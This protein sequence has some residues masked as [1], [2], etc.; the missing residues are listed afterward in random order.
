M[1]LQRQRELSVLLATL[2]FGC[3]SPSGLRPPLP[4]SADATVRFVSLEGGCWSLATANAVYEPVNLPSTFRIDGLAVHVALRDAPDRVS[5]C[6]MA[7][8][9]YVDSIRVR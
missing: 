4:L 8:L 3:N 5:I 6:M 7:P 2:A 1:L 9:V